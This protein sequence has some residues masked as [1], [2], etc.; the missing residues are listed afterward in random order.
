MP[1]RLRAALQKAQTA[2]SYASL[3]AL[4]VE[5][6]R[7][8]KELGRPTGKALSHLI[9]DGQS[10]PVDSHWVIEDL[11][12]QL[13]SSPEAAASYMVIAEALWY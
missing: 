13:Q 7:V 6:E 12:I 4:A 11:A 8:L 9:G 3:D 5:L 10:L 2:P 1:A